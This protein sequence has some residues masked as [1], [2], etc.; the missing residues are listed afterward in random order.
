MVIFFLHVGTRVLWVFCCQRIHWNHLVPCDKF[1]NKE[2]NSSNDYFNLLLVSLSD[3]EAATSTLHHSYGLGPRGPNPPHGAPQAQGPHQPAPG[4]SGA[5]RPEEQH[6]Q[7]YKPFF[8][9]QPSQPYLPM[10]SLQW[11]VP[12]PMPVSYNPYYSYPGLG[13]CQKTPNVLFSILWISGVQCSLKILNL[14]CMLSSNN[15]CSLR[16]F[17]LYVWNNSCFWIK[18]SCRSCFSN[19]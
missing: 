2:Q 8:Y 6:Q 4:P 3:M 12:V 9:I 11:P 13:K 14:C 10:Q 17:M 18:S 7:H 15:H 1:A 5:S 16:P 19:C